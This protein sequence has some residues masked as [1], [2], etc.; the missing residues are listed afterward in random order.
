MEGHRPRPITL[1]PIVGAEGAP[2]GA[3]RHPPN[4]IN[5]KALWISRADDPSGC[6]VYYE[7]EA[8][9]T[10]GRTRHISVKPSEDTTV[11]WISKP[12]SEPSRRSS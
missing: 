3:W 4:E 2:L 10:D 7:V 12:S 9:L 8:D 5:G 1:L 6:P 11:S